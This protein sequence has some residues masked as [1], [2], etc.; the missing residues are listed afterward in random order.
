[1][2]ILLLA[3]AVALGVS[4][5]CSF[6]EA[7]LLSLTPA[8]IAEL[9]KKDAKAGRIWTR[10]KSDIG[11]PISVILLVNTTAHTI[12]AAVAGAKWSDLYGDDYLWAFTLF[13]TFLMLQY[14]EILPKTLGVRYRMFFAENSAVPLDLGIKI[15]SP[16]IALI[17]WINRPF[18]RTDAKEDPAASTIQEI[19]SL[20]SLARMNNAIGSKQEKIISSATHLS[21]VTAS[22][23]MIPLEQVTTFS[24]N[25]DIRE[26]F[27]LAHEDL[28]TRYPV[29]DA[30]D[31]SKLVGYVNF[32]ELVYF[33][34]TNPNNPS[35]LGIVRPLHFVPP[36][37]S[38]S[39]LLKLFVDQHNHMVVVTSR[40]GGNLG[41]VTV[42]DVIEELVGEIEDEF[43]RLPN[44]VHS[45]A[46]GVWMA[47]GGVPMTVLSD[48][49]GVP[50]G[51]NGKTL[52]EWLSEALGTD[53][54]P[55]MSIRRE[56]YE[57]AVR[58]TKRGR[59]FDATITDLFASKSMT[60]SKKKVK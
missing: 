37:T 5:V 45:L 7:G 23:V 54:T 14:T 32:K 11:R 51:G 24:A 57:I 10:F 2:G 43:D 29:R 59:I 25:A 3:M 35:F 34:S 19:N 15:L 56:R 42:E 46:G 22:Q 13:F 41:I 21:G 58:R 48:R 40:G 60:N 44:Y 18:E 30:D 33:M 55:G 17:H 53:A 50:L 47:G 38:A 4:F 9:T 20:T 27:L 6:T 36:E 26:A 16:L 39:D 1:M 52:A 49:L 28:H 8:N 31:R 12:G